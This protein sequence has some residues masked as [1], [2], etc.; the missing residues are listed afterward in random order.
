MEKIIDKDWNYTLY[1]DGGKLI[2]S[3]LCGTVAMFDLNVP[4]NEEEKED[5]YLKGEVF[6]DDLAEKI[7]FSPP[8]YQE[9]SIDI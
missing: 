6:L 2:L 1:K 3:V 9:R 4:L 8:A 5:F 7:R